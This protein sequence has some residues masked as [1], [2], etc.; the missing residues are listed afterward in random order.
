MSSPSTKK[1]KPSTSFVNLP[2]TSNWSGV[3]GRRPSYWT[4]GGDRNPGGPKP[5]PWIF[6]WVVFGTTQWLAPKVKDIGAGQIILPDK[7]RVRSRARIC[8][9]IG[10]ARSILR[11]RKVY[12]RTSLFPSKIRYM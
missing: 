6:V 2:Q 7:I 1:T 4:G 8:F 3:H 10:K 9:A 5:R 12:G 11:F